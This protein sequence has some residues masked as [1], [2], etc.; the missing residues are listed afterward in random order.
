MK[1]MLKRHEG[2]KLKP[3]KCSAG[4]L[5][6]GYGRNLDDVG[7]SKKEAEIMLDND[8]ARAGSE[9]MRIFP[10]MYKYSQ[11]RQAVLINMMFNLGRTK[12]LTFKRFIEAVC[13][14]DWGKAAYEMEDSLWFKQVGDRGKELKELMENG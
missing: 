13:A 9:C 2:L 5:T 3:Y 7:I 8:I 11:A 1:Q 12:F 14:E 4:K 10:M 6:I